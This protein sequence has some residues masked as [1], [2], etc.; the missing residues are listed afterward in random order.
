MGT[1]NKNRLWTIFVIP[2]LSHYY[3]NTDRSQYVRMAE[4]SKAPDSSASFPWKEG[5]AFWSSIEGVG[6]N[7]TSDMN[8][9][10]HTL[11]NNFFFL[12]YINFKRFKREYNFFYFRNQLFFNK[13]VFEIQSSIEKK[14]KQQSFL[15]QSEL[16]A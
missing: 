2:S 12:K 3:A 9:F 16:S 8:F 13:Y 5:S 11:S 15:L 7:P 6:S 1:H 4:R 14:E 10:F